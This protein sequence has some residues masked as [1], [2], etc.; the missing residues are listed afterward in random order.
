MFNFI[1]RLLCMTF[2]LTVSSGE[3]LRVLGRE[4]RSSD[5]F[6]GGV[7]NNYPCYL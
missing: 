1:K 2:R 5:F 3:K 4:P 7:K 6:P